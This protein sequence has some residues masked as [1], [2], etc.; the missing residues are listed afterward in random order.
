MADYKNGDTAS[1]DAQQVRRSQAE[2]QRSGRTTRRR[3]KRRRVNPLLYLLF[4]LVTSALLASVGWLLASDLCAFNTEYMETTVKITADDDISSIAEKLEDAG[5][6][7]Y[8]WFFKL[9]AG[10]A[11]AQDKIGVGTYEL[12]TDM[13]Y[14]ALIVGMHNSSGNMN[15]DTVRVTIP[16]GYTVAQ[17]IHLLAEKGVNT[18]EALTEAAKTYDFDYT[19]IDNNAQDISRLEGY[20]FPDTYDFYV[21]E[22]PGSALNRLISNFNSKLDD[23]LLAASEARGYNL[24]KIVTIASLI[25]KETDGT[26]R[27]TIA[28][29]IYNRLNNPNGGTQG[30]LQIDAT[31]QY[32]LPEGEI[33]S[34][35]DYNTVDSPYN[36][37]LNKGLP[38]GPIS[39]PGM[40]SIMAAIN[41]EKTNY[42]YYA[43][44]DDK[45]H[46]FFSSYSEFQAFL[47][48]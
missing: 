35:E 8:K 9:F 20:L 22:K 46:H 26:D 3:K 12:N 31:I 37:Y 47:N 48:S 2:H 33:V 30:Y 43:L 6:I 41:P 27:A 40:E 44:G 39:N 29:V 24:K 15:T 17:T 23:E 45:H 13:D 36:T 16:E 14:R 11:H 4:V 19:F 25:E 42:F 34:E 28:S 1:W 10:V 18:E 38:P 7:E 32:V 21:N 5:L